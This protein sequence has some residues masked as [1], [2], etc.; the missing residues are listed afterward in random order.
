MPRVARQVRRC[1]R[2]LPVRMNMNVCVF[3]VSW[4]PGADPRPLTY[5]VYSTVCVVRVVALVGREA[6]VLS[7]NPSDRSPKFL[8]C[9]VL[10]ARPEL[11]ASLGFLFRFS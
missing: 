8:M 1:E 4:T 5:M 3:V 10:N 2:S 9:G 7:H 11:Y 6:Q